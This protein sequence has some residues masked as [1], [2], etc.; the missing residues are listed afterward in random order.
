MA[1]RFSYRI[2]A[3]ALNQCSAQINRQSV[4]SPDSTEPSDTNQSLHD[5]KQ[6][7][8]ESPPSCIDLLTS[9]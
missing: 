1:L 8:Q 9:F 5:T 7:M 3:E 4:L 6:S 2:N